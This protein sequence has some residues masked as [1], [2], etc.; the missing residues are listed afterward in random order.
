VELLDAAA[1]ENGGQV[2]FV[3][4]Q[5]IFVQGDRDLRV[6]AIAKSCRNAI[7]H[8]CE[9][10][11]VTVE[12]AQRDGAAVISVADDGLGIPI[13]ERQNV[14]KHFYRL[15]RSRSSP[16][17]G[18]GL[19]VVAAVARLHGAGIEILDNLPGLKSLLRFPSHDTTAAAS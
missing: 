6:D 18:L 16:G 3:G 17:N 7:K 13:D 11:Q 12:V 15:E 10:G 5:R 8:G 14:F 4:D 19:S 2:G 1:E 9:S